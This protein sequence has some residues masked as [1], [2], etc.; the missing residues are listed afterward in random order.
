VAGRVGAIDMFV[1]A[2]S[3]AD[4]SIIAARPGSASTSGRRASTGIGPIGIAA[5]IVGIAVDGK[6][7]GFAPLFFY[8]HGT[9]VLADR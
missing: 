7:R 8:P 1:V 4:A 9:G 3:A 2:V 6:E 5:I